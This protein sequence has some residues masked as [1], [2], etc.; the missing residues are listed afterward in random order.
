MN[1]NELTGS[2]T[3]FIGCAEPDLGGGVRTHNFFDPRYCLVVL[4]KGAWPA[5]GSGGSD[6]MFIGSADPDLGGGVRTHNFFDRSN[7]S[8]DRAC[9][10]AVHHV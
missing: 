2:E 5:P 1:S 8:R 6:S 10:R 9:L 4:A 7:R 3:M